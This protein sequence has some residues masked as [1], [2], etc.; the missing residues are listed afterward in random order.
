MVCI[1]SIKLIFY[2]LIRNPD[3][4]HNCRLQAINSILDIVYQKA[5]VYMNPDRAITCAQG[6]SDCDA[7]NFGAFILG[8]V[9]LHLW[10]PRTPDSI[11]T[12]LS[13]LARQLMDM[14]FP[15]GSGHSSCPRIELEEEIEAVLNTLPSPVLESHKVHRARQ[16]ERLYPRV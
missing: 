1:K 11:A 7:L 6:M 14:T 5:N 10:P 15:V 16:H 13:D 3:S 9:K 2:L 12:S 8:L 4:I